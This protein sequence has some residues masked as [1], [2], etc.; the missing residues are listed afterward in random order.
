M[1]SEFKNLKNSIYNYI[2]NN[3]GPIFE[4]TDNQIGQATQITAKQFNYAIGVNEGTTGN[5]FTFFFN[6]TESKFNNTVFINYWTIDQTLSSESSDYYVGFPSFLAEILKDNILNSEDATNSTEYYKN[7]LNPYIGFI[8]SNLLEDNSL[9][10]KSTILSSPRVSNDTIIK[11]NI[12]HFIKAIQ[13]AGT[14]DICGRCTAFWGNN[15]PYEFLSVRPSAQK[16]CG[17]CNQ[18]MDSAPTY[19]GIP[20]QDIPPIECQPQCNKDVTIL[21]AYQGTSTA[22]NTGVSGNSDADI[23]NMNFEEKNCVGQTVCIISNPNIKA[24]GGSNKIIFNQQ[25]QGCQDGNCA[26]YIDTTEG[27]I[28]LLSDGENG[29]QN[30]VTFNNYC[31]IAYCTT[32]KFN[33]D[34]S[35]SYVDL[36]CNRLNPSSTN[37]EIYNSYDHSAKISPNSSNES[38]NN[39]LYSFKSWSPN[40]YFL[41]ILVFIIVAV[42]SLDIKEIPVYLVKGY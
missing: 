23:I 3:Y 30:T 35:V 41:I 38:R 7:F 21:Q 24:Q 8:L 20:V 33:I 2:N 36:P 25:C 1:A 28:D 22:V 18:L 29:L 39:F 14:L 31:A 27:N 17:C 34:G 19:Y 42:L 13:G 15:N 9:N 16:L 10:V 12:F 32:K 11:K 26:C 6:N 5:P 40:M 37:K 4:S